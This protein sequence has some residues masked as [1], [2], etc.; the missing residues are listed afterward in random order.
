MGPKSISQNLAPPHRSRLHR[1]SPALW[2]DPLG[3]DR[4]LPVSTNLHGFEGNLGSQLLRRFAGSCDIDHAQVGAHA[5]P[6]DRGV[7]ADPTPH[8]GGAI[9][10]RT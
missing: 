3:D 2:L 6:C 4:D 10:R 7:S 9:R 1:R 5:K 8:P